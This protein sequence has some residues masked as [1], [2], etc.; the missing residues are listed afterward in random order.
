MHFKSDSI[1]KFK[2]PDFILNGETIEL[3]TEFRYLGHIL[4]NN[5]KDD[6]DIER[7]RRTLFIIGNTLIRTFYMCTFE[8]KIELFRSYCSDMNTPHLWTKYSVTAIR[9]L[10]T[11]YHNSLKILNGVSKREETSPLCK[12]LSSCN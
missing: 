9:K 7:Q 2:V 12:I 10:Y 6:N 3:V 11:V 4:T 1:A 5:M 8:V